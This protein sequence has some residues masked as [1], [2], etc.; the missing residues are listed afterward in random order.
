[1]SILCSL[2]LNYRSSTTVAEDYAES[3]ATHSKITEQ[4]EEKMINSVSEEI[5]V[6]IWYD[7]V[8]NEVVENSIVDEIGYSIDS[9][10]EQYT[11]PDE[12]LIPCRCKL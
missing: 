8:D 9:L 6:V 7:G 2:T 5:P 12:E 3:S 1:M 11:K 10:E 4:L